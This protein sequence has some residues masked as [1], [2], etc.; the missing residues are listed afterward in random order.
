MEVTL[1]LRAV[2]GL[3]IV[4]L[5][6][7]FST[8]GGRSNE[9]LAKAKLDFIK[10]RAW[11]RIVAPVW[12]GT[13]VNL[14]ALWSGTWTW[15]LLLFIPAMM[16]VTTMGHGYNGT[17]VWAKIAKRVLNGFV[18]ATPAV[19][20]CIV[21]GAWSLLVLQYVV[22]VTASLIWGVTN[23]KSAPTEEYWLNVGKILFMP[24]II[25]T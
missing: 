19:I 25:L 7:A 8:L 10:N 24:S 3:F 4:L 14:L 21:S 5:S 11:G 2:V 22:A 17:N 23:P 6:S 20:L 16:A 13:S 12:F 18:W 9:E 15:I 1:L